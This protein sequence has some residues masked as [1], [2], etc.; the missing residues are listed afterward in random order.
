MGTG[1]LNAGDNPA[2]GQHRIQVGGGTRKTPSSS[3][4]MAHFAPMQILPYFLP[5]GNY[6]N[7]HLLHC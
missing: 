3:G 1:E 2:M 5:R 4:L 6:I 7:F